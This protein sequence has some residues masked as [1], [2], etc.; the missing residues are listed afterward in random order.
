MFFPLQ[1]TKSHEQT[2]FNLCSLCHRWEYS[3]IHGQFPGGQGNNKFPVCVCDDVISICLRYK[4]LLASWE[5][6]WNFVQM[7]SVSTYTRHFDFLVGEI[8]EAAIH[9]HK[10]ALCVAWAFVPTDG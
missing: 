2:E 4:P 9:E 6:R 10:A 3:T 8:G 1:I 5:I 7:N